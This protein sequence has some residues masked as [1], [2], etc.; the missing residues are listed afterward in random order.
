MEGM[1]RRF[2]QKTTEYNKWGVDK[3]DPQRYNEVNTWRVWFCRFDQKITKYYEQ[4]M[5]EPEANLTVTLRCCNPWK[6][7]AI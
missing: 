5:D 4:G 2:N 6:N 7:L 1:V 3:K